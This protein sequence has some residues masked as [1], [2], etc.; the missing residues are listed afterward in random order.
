VWIPVT[1]QLKAQVSADGMVS[2]HSPREKENQNRFSVDWADGAATAGEHEA[3]V[4][5][6]A[7]FKQVPAKSEALSQLKIGTFAPEGPCTHT[8]NGNV[9]TY[10]KHGLIDKDTVFEVDGRFLKNV[11]S[12][13]TV[14]NKSFRNPPTFMS[15]G[16]KDLKPDDKVLARETIAEVESLLKHLFHH[17]NTPSF[18]GKKTDPAICELK[19]ISDLLR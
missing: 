3:V 17:Q 16:P 5:F 14:A 13:V 12:R 9:K 1:C 18:I 2:I 10:T 7:V 19:P 11:E 4:E 6:L 8:C 15:P